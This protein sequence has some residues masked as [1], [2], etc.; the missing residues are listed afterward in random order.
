MGGNVRLGEPALRVARSPSGATVTTSAGVR[1]FDGCVIATHADD[2]LALLA[3]PDDTERRLLGAFSY[4]DNRAVLHRDPSLMPRRRRMWASWNYLGSSTGREGDLS[5]TYW[6]NRLQPL[7]PASPD[8]FV[9][10]NPKRE[11][12]AHH[13]GAEFDYRHPLF[14]S[15]AMAAQ[16]QLWQL[17]GVRR[18]WFC[19]SYFGYGF[20]EDGLQAGLAVAEEI[21]GVRRPW[22]VSRESDRIHLPPSRVANTR[23]ILEAAE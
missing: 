19:G 9:T 3:D 5:V 10:L 8:L 11:I 1:S 23:P 18:T 17:Q 6:M 12:P 4:I 15:A 20:H 22:T 2:A 14:D 16:R 7:G 13:H 21:G